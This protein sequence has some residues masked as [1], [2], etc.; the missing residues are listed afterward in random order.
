MGESTEEMRAELAGTRAVIVANADWERGIGTSIRAGVSAADTLGVANVLVMLCDQPFVDA[1]LLGAL[2]AKF[3]GGG[4]LGA[5]CRYG[6]TIGVP[7][8]FGPTLVRSLRI[9]EDEEGAKKV[10]A[11]AAADL[12][13]ID[14]PSA[15]V[16]VDTEDDVKKHR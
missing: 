6:E 16:D 9:L 14:A 10:L 3:D 7:A 2:V 13:V 4:V 12:A 1:A 11:R 8:L 15:A 5:A